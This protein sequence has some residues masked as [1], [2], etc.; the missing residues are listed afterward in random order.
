MWGQAHQHPQPSPLPADDDDANSYENVL[1][2]KQ[3]TESGE[4]ASPAPGREPG[5][6]PACTGDMLKGVTGLEA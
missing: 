4:A 5:L 1:I 6:L 3:T 2:C